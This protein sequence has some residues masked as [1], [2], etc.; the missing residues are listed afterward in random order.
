MALDSLIRL[1]QLN[2][3]ELSGYLGQVVF[4]SLINSGITINSGIFPTASGTENLGS[5]LLPFDEIYARGIFLP[6]GSGIWFGPHFFTAFQSGTDAVIKVGSYSI[7]S[8]PIG[9]SI[10]GPSGD[11]GLTGPTGATGASGISVTGAVSVNTT[12]FRLLFSNGTSGNSIALPSGA[13]GASG[14]SVT[15]FLQSGVYIYGLFSN[16]RT[17]NA[18]LLN[19]GARGIQGK[20]GGIVFNF[21]DFTGFSGAQ[22]EPRAYIYDIDPLGNT[23]NPDVN[24]IRGMSYD[25]IYSGLNT[26]LVTIT[27]N[28]ID[29]TTGV[30]ASNYFVESGITG[31]LKFVVFNTDVTGWASNAHTG[32]YIRSE[33][34]AEYTDIVT[35]VVTEN[36]FYN[37]EENGARNEQ[38]F[39]VKL[40]ADDE[41]LWGFQKYNFYN[42]S[43]IDEDGA[44]GFYVLGNLN[45]SYYGPVGPSGAT[46]PQ[47][48]PGTQGERGIPGS[49]GGAGT[50]VT[51]VERVGNDIRFLFSD[52]TASDYVTLPEGGDTGPQGPEG[53]RGTGEQGPMGPMGPT[54]M[55]DRYYA[56]F[57]YTETYTSGSGNALDIKASGGSSWVYTTGDNRTFKAGD[58]IRFSNPDLISKSYSVWQ[59]VLFADSPASRAQYFYAYVTDFTPSI[60]EISCVMLDTPAPLG[61]VGG[62]VKLGQYAQ[63]EVN[64]GGLG[65]PGATGPTGE[66]G[67]QGAKGDTGNPIFMINAPASGLIA[68]QTYNLGFNTYD[69]WNLYF[70]GEGHIINFNYDA[71]S[72]GQTVQLAIYNSGSLNNNNPVPLISWD[73]S[74]KFPYNTTAPFPNPNTVSIYTFLRYPD[75]HNGNRRVF[76]TYA[77]NYN[78]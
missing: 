20:A 10:I 46:G 54:G 9:L 64:L 35:D 27:G 18:I 23:P 22:I 59:R 69:A 24:L 41:Y 58:E 76:C 33:T 77:S 45:I 62:Y 31:Y 38:T 48:I 3:A 7:T 11:I 74:V 50:S 73:G 72:T 57:A 34:S 14:A 5:A 15:G 2:Q 43:P 44:W 61:T 21:S 28:G 16:G 26:A 36:I 49:D 65:S 13:S 71:F 6:S 30:L 39:I 68:N 55:A 78:V 19:S 52:G 12:G 53:P 8:S 32:R 66:T 1:R 63:L 17:G 42:Q 47:G 40:A 70:T 25:F 4:P 75:W 67:P 29:Y 51:G 60:G 56:T 37:I